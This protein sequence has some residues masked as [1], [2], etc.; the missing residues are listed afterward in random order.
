MKAQA[1]PP[2]IAPTS[3]EDEQAEVIRRLEEDIIF[4]RFA[5]G[6]RL[7]EDTLM[8]RYGAS[9]HFVR[10]ALFQLERQGI[11]LREKNV[12]ATVRFYSAEE[13]RQIYE[14]R[15]MLTRQA[16]LMIP[17][18]ASASLIAELSELQRQYCARADAQDMRGIH[19]TNDAFHLALFSAC[20]N[21]YLVRSLQDYMNLTLPMRA[22]NLADSEGL[23]LSRRQHELMIELLKGRDSWALAQLC[24]DHMQFSKA[25]YLAR[26]A[27]EK[28][29]Q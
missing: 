20:G 4:G 21:P 25:D 1:A 8:Q 9:R 29:P 24:V 28:M 22:K 13:V 27:G 14:V 17:L 26:I 23:A 18:P 16:A 12:G 5:P 19:E 10:Q 2:D 7:V 6:L 15:E 3:R 11:V